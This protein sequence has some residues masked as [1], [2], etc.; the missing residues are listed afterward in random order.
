MKV[1]DKNR[2]ELDFYTLDQESDVRVNVVEGATVHAGFPAPV[3][4]AF[5]A[6]PIDLN[7]ELMKHPATTYMVRV[8]GDSMKDE[9]IESGD[10]VLVD[11]SLYPT[12]KNLCICMYDGEFCLKRIVHRGSRVLLMSGN[13]KYKPIEVMPGSELMNWGV[14]LWIIK[15]MY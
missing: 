6:P 3:D 8:V 15:K 14:V 1:K 4:D 9:G 11:R 7:K 10:L 13:I 5:M 2:T 12:E